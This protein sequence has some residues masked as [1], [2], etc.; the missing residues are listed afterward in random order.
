MPLKICHFTIGSKKLLSNILFLKKHKLYLLFFQ[1]K[2]QIAIAFLNLD[3][4]ICCFYKKRD[5]II[6][7][8]N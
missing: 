4:S 2:Q 6:G 7:L 8:E 5:Y 3:N 1:K